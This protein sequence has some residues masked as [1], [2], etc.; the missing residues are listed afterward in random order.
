MKWDKIPNLIFLLQPMCTPLFD[1]LFLKFEKKILLFKSVQMGLAFNSYVP[2]W[3]PDKQTN[4]LLKSWNHLS[5]YWDQLIIIES[6][7]WK[8]IIF[9]AFSSMQIPGCHCITEFVAVLFV[10]PEHKVRPAN[11]AVLQ[12]KKQQ[13][14]LY[15][16][17]RPCQ[18]KNT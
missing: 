12:F 3:R 18:F 16:H 11:S 17:S 6:Q 8:A 14:I 2:I 9:E 10:P 5:E 4:V 13:K 1:L 7:K 15:M